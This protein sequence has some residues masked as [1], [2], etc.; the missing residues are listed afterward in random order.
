MILTRTVTTE[1]PVDFPKPVNA[2]LLSAE[3]YEECEDLIRPAQYSDRAPNIPSAWYL[4]TPGEDDPDAITIA[5]C[6]V[7][8][9]KPDWEDAGPEDL[10][11]EGYGTGN[12][13]VLVFEESLFAAGAKPGDQ[14]SVGCW[15]FTVISDKL[16]LCDEYISTEVFDEGTN[17]YED[18]AIK[19]R[20]DAWFKDIL[21]F[22]QRSNEEMG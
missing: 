14:F 16:A 17:D 8:E 18:S 11:D 21:K 7:E 6:G 19:Q 4:R 13:P 5:Y 9:T 1:H 12:R 2:T 20:V 15:P 22:W 10:F 3:E